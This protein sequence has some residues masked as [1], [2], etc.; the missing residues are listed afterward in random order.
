MEI[1]G[2]VSSR[3][4]PDPEIR[5]PSEWRSDLGELPDRSLSPVELDPTGPERDKIVT[6]RTWDPLGL[7]PGDPV[8][9]WDADSGRRHN[10]Q[11]E[12]CPGR[13]GCPGESLTS[14][15]FGPVGRGGRWTRS[16]DVGRTSGTVDLGRP[17]GE[18][19]GQ[20]RLSWGPLSHRRVDAR[21]IGARRRTFLCYYSHWKSRARRRSTRSW[22]RA[23]F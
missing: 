5:V 18:G 12:T 9:Q 8:D 1:P 14:W 4:G 15:F 17:V 19:L 16:R 2:V 20:S 7:G 10:G 13:D 6:F 11:N 21:S 22:G 23:F 3:V